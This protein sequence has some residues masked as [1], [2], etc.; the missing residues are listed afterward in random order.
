MAEKLYLNLK[1]HWKDDDSLLLFSQKNKQKI[2][3]THKNKD[4]AA[5]G[6]SAYVFLPDIRN[7]LKKAYRLNK[8]NSAWKSDLSIALI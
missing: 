1:K 2:V 6:G 4:V 8:L 3:A 5:N 7:P